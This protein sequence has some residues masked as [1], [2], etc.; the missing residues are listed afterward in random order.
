MKGKM[1]LEGLM[2]KTA[3]LAEKA[4]NAGLRGTERAVKGTLYMKK[5]R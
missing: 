4:T 3:G 1:P 2:K 5:R